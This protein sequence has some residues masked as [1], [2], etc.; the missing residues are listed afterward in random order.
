METFSSKNSAELCL[1]A[2]ALMLLP[3]WLRQF[4]PQREGEGGVPGPARAGKGGVLD[5]EQQWRTGSYMVRLS[6]LIVPVRLY[7]E[8]KMHFSEAVR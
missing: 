7:C 5:G 6:A 3:L 4:S 2:G 8:T 1:R